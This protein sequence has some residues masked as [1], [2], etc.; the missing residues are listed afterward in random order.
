MLHFAYG[1]N[2]N[3]ALMAARCPGA[4]AQGTAVLSNWRFIIGRAGYASIAPVRGAVVRGVLWRLGVRDFAAV[5]AYESLDSGLYVRRTVPVR[6]DRQ[7]TPAWVYIAG[8][9]GEGTPRPSYMDVVIEAARDWR[10]PTLY[11]E[12]LRRWSTSGWRG[13]RAKETGEIG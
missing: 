11:I 6:S 8:W 3:R 2:M 9:P 12:S 5:D 4:V 7:L 1:S 10:L 13:A